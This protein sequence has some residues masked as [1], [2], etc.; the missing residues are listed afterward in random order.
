MTHGAPHASG[1]TM[2]KKLNASMQ[3]LIGIVTPYSWDESDQVSMVSLSAT[4]DEEYIIENSERFFELIR[5]PILAI[6]LVKGGRKI[7]R[8]INIKKFKRLDSAP[9]VD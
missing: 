8:A 9:F 7:H 4:D 6:G 2:K 1:M 5:Q 3:T